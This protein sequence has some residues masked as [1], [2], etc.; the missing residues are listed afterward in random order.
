METHLTKSSDLEQVKAEFEAWRKQRA[1]R[2]PI[3]E[4]LWIAAIELLNHYPVSTV[5]KQLRLNLRQ[6]KQRSGAHPHLHQHS[7][8]KQ[9][10]LEIKPGAIA[11]PASLS[12]FSNNSNQP[13]ESIPVDSLRAV[14]RIAF[15]RGDGSSLTI[16]LPADS[17]IIPAI[18]ADLLRA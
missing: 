13:V 5:R 8:P 10:F 15:Q 2:E 12:R 6:L 3:P 4:R 9:Q 7:L 1:G 17:N 18:C 11:A 16:Q 14:C